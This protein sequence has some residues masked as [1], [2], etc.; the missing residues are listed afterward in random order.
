AD[1]IVLKNA[2]GSSFLATGVSET[3]NP[4][5]SGVN[6]L[7]TG[8]LT[9]TNW[10]FIWAISDGVVNTKLLL[11]LSNTNP[12]LPSGYTYKA[13]IGCSYRYASNFQ[14][15]VQRGNYIRCY[16]TGWEIF[17][18]STANTLNANLPVPPVITKECVISVGFEGSVG[19]AALTVT[20]DDGS[21]IAQITSINGDN[22]SITRK[23]SIEFIYVPVTLGSLLGYSLSHNTAGTT[24]TGRIAG[25]RI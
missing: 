12:T 4:A 23:D 25:F 6:G 22:Q 16:G 14:S 3:L 20:G 9:T 24:F 21:L 11:S 18:I 15:F 8:S 19:E 2:I 13:L 7:D 17:Q 5:T 10:Y 1:E